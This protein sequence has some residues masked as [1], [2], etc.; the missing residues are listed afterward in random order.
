MMKVTQPKD[1]I[2]VG[3]FIFSNEKLL[4]VLTVFHIG[5]C[6]YRVYTGGIENETL[7]CCKNSSQTVHSG[8]ISMDFKNLTRFGNLV[9]NFV[10]LV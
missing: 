7:D 8:Q 5:K 3:D 4:K 6:C 10:T 9:F 1:L 2:Q